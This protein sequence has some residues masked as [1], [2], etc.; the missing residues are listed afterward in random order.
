[1]VC[2]FVLGHDITITSCPL[3]V[4]DSCF[5]TPWFGYMLFKISPASS[6]GIFIN[7]I[8]CFL[9][10]IILMEH[11]V[12]ETINDYCSANKLHCT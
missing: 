4:E 1:M 11:D 2:S 5:N 10:L 7:E 8:Y 9:A 12:W 6:A 3:M